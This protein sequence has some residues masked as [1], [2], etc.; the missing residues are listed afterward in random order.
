MQPLVALLEDLQ[1]RLAVPRPDSDA[2]ALD[3]TPHPLALPL[4]RRAWTSFS[5]SPVQ[6]MIVAGEQHWALCPRCV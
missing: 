4:A 3:E 5:P 1:T 6:S 2:A